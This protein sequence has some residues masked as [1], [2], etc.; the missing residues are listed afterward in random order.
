[1]MERVLQKR[2]AEFVDRDEEM[3]RFRTMLKSSDKPIM[4]VWG[5]AGIGKT[6]LLAR[7]IHEC[8]VRNLRKSEIVWKDV[9]P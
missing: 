9:D 2:L 8:A 6:S 7:M 3:R 1:M 5:E 4:V